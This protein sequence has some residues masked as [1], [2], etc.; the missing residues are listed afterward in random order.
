VNCPEWSRLL[1]PRLQGGDDPA[2]WSEAMAHAETCSAC[3]RRALKIDPTLVFA[4]LRD[5]PRPADDDA[6]LE[7]LG[8]RVRAARRARSLEGSLARRRERS[9]PAAAA[10]MLVAAG[11]LLATHGGRVTA[12]GPT[13]E[14]A[15][16]ADRS[17]IAAWAGDGRTLP[18]MEVPGQPLVETLDRPQARVYQLGQD[19]ELSLVMIVDESLDV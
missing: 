13:G 12:P 3:R 7:G 15:D 6:F 11:L 17:A 8:E 10:A 9:V 19:E 5:A 4:R 14:R 2:L 16:T 18:A 1:E